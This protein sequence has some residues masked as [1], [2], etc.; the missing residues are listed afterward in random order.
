ML[1]TSLQKC[2]Q[3]WT[4]LHKIAMFALINKNITPCLNLVVCDLPQFY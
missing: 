2:M 1:I 4:L 3:F